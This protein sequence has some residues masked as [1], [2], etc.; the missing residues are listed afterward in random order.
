MCTKCN[1]FDASE[2]AANTWLT[3]TEL[4][5]LKVQNVIVR[6]ASTAGNGAIVN[7]A[8]VCANC[9]ITGAVDLAGPEI[10]YPVIKT[11]TCDECGEQTLIKLKIEF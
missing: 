9:R 11:Y 2:L 6:M 10:N 3:Y 7:F 1:A 5:I 4:D 8:P